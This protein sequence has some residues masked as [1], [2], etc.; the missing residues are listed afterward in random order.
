MAGKLETKIE[1]NKPI[2]I[3]AIITSTNVVPRS[4][5]LILNFKFLINL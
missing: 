2:I 5:F 3:M 4:E 1:D